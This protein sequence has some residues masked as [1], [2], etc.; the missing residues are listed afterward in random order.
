M[1]LDRLEFPPSPESLLSLIHIF[2][3]QGF[4]K[5]AGE[6]MTQ[7]PVFISSKLDIHEAALAFSKHGIRR[8]PVVEG[9]KLVGLL[10]LKDLARKKVF[11][12]E[13]GHI[14]YAVSNFDPSN[15]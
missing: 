12:A 6:I 8:L 9:E 1:P 15:S 2:V 10:T 3:R 14:I 13:I 7:D 4:G 5:T 11:T